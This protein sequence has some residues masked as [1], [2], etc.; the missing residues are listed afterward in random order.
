GVRTCPRFYQSNKAKI[1]GH[2]FVF[3]DVKIYNLFNSLIFNYFY[4]QHFYWHCRIHDW[5]PG[6][7][8]QKFKE[9]KLLEGN[10]SVYTT[11]HL[12]AY[13]KKPTR[14]FISRTKQKSADMNLIFM[15]CRASVYTT[16]QMDAYRKSLKNLNFLKA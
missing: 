13:R 2:E 7:L 1:S 15:M 5:A 8:S 3:H 12:D 16:G 10:A 6:C 4:S 11:G 9:F 14:A